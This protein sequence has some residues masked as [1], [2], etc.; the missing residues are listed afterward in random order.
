MISN[1]PFFP[2][3][4]ST[5]ASRVDAL[6][7]FLLGVSGFFSVLI[8]TLIIVFAVKYRRSA[9][10]EPNP[11]P[12]GVLALEITWTVVP[13]LLTM[14]MFVW[15]ASIFVAMSRPP[16]DALQAYVVGRRWMW[17][18]QH[19]DGRR[20]IDQIH[21]PVGQ[22]VKLTMT[23]E[24]V[25]HSFFIPAF[26]VK[27]DVVPGRYT[28][29]WFEATKP[30]TYHLFCAEYCGT[31]HSHMIGQVIALEPA[32][33]QAWLAGAGAGQSMEAA[34]GALFEQ[35]GCPS[36]HRN[37]TE[38]RGPM[39]VGLYNRVVKLQDGRQVV[40]DDG[41]IRESI[42]NPGAKVVAGYQPIMPTFQG[43]VSEEGLLQL[44]AYIKSLQPSQA[45]AGATGGA[46][47]NA[48][49]V[50]ASGGGNAP[51][52]PPRPR[53]QNDTHQQSDAGRPG[54]SQGPG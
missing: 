24:D 48:S 40:A 25:I 54:A 6:F 46:P 20:E 35:L 43:L 36:C 23:S 34:G 22:S 32:A 41:Y 27:Q 50:P 33:Y 18:V 10:A 12:K 19:I 16:D 42:L 51:T 11:A 39:L 21:V 1:L 26:R 30:G 37:D 31:Q 47:P 2:E 13:F 28:T 53:P 17:K 8:A 29:L 3:R 4:A 15:G 14:V 44:L 9:K 5:M 38:G 7:F 52:S 45:G 49:S